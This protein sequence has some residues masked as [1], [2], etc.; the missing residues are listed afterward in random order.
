MACAKISVNYA[1]FERHISYGRVYSYRV[2]WNFIG[3]FLKIELNNVLYDRHYQNMI[4]W[5][6]CTDYAVV[7]AWYIMR[8]FWMHD[9]KVTNVSLQG[10]LREARQFFTLNKLWAISWIPNLNAMIFPSVASKTDYPIPKYIFYVVYIITIINFSSL[11]YTK[12]TIL[13]ESDYNHCTLN[14]IWFDCA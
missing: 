1:N 3:K 4:I 9:C 12:P 14:I 11:G 7:F 8:I 5:F 6:M 10:V 13:L 2:R